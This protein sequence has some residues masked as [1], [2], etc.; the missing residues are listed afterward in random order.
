MEFNVHVVEIHFVEKEKANDCKG[1]THK[2]TNI[3]YIREA[4]PGRFAIRKSVSNTRF[5]YFLGR[6]RI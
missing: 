5:N 6:M 2:K 4:S 1:I 3:Y